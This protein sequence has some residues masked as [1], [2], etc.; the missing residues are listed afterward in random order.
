MPPARFALALPPTQLAWSDYLLAARAA[1]G[2]AF[3]S[4]W[5]FDHLMPIYGNMDGPNFECYTT[6]AALAAAT[7]RIRL[8]ALVTGVIYRNPALQIKEATQIDVISGGRLD[9]GIGAGWAQREFKAFNIPFPPEPKVRI[10]TLRETLDIAKLLWSGDPTRKVSYSGQYVSIT[11]C[12]L[13]PQPFQRPRPPI[14]IGGGGEQLTLRVVARHADIWHG[15]GD[16][17]TLQHKIRLID[18][19]ARGYGRDPASIVK[20]TNISLWVGQLPESVVTL[21]HQTTGRPIEQIRQSFISGTPEAIEARI[22]QLIELGIG[23]FMVAG[24]SPQ[25]IDNWQ[26]IS[27]QVLPRFAN[28]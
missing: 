26:K 12:F 21:I 16:P 8:G 9:F 25:L 14:L 15:F 28:G 3:E 20:S 7:R 4:F 13:N 10:G 5:G 23:Y 18:E 22:R 19:Y 6:M 2:M 11:D 1:D 17:A 27:D 24:G